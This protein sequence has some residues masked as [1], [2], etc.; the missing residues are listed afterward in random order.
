MLVGVSVSRGTAR[1]SLSLGT[2]LPHF[3][4]LSTTGSHAFLGT[5][6]GVIEVSGA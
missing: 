1:R 6:E 2:P 4:S 5:S 3:A